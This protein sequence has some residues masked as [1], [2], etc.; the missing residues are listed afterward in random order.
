MLLYTVLSIFD[1]SKCKFDQSAGTGANIPIKQFASSVQQCSLFA[2]GTKLQVKVDE[3]TKQTLPVSE[4]VLEELS[5][6]KQKT[7]SGIQ[8]VLMSL[9][10][11]GIA[12]VVTREKCFADL[13][14]LVA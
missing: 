11:S 5:K 4:S 3:M 8:G 13:A 14:N 9:L 10:T 7:F 12:S 6:K 2:A 1:Q